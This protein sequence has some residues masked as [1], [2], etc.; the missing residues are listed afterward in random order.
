MVDEEFVDEFDLE[1]GE[2]QLHHHQ[3][4]VG[5]LTTIITYYTMSATGTSSLNLGFIFFTIPA[6]KL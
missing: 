6:Y 4:Q 2:G 5:K 3:Q 1:E